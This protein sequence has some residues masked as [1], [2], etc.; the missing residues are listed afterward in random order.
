MTTG[1][2]EF[3]TTDGT[4]TTVS[5]GTFAIVQEASTSPAYYNGFSYGEIVS[6]SFLFFEA[7]LLSFALLWVV[8]KGVKIKQ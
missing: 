3:T 7:A 6:T 8:V 4:S 2:I 1:T 5:T